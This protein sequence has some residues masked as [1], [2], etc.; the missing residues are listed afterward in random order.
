MIATVG[1]LLEKAARD[2]AADR[3]VAEARRDA[4]VLLG[5]ALGVTRAWVTTHPDQVADSMLLEDSSLLWP[6]GWV[7]TRWPTC[8]A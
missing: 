2:L 4:Q 8:S 7:V 5:F 6:S 1:A 3:D